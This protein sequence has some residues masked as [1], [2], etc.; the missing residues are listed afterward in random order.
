MYFSYTPSPPS[1][2]YYSS[3]TMEIPSISSSRPQS[4]SCAFPSWPRRSSMKSE[5]GEQSHV[6]SSFS[7]EELSFGLYPSVFDDA[8]EDCMPLATLHRSTSRSMCEPQCVVI[9]SG[10]LMCELIAQHA[11]GET[12]NKEKSKKRAHGSRKS[13]HISTTSSKHMSPIM[14]ADE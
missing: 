10:A 14:E 1:T 7:D 6:S 12:V 5:S 11:Q 4:P 9:D 8:Q 13:R 3:S 2:S